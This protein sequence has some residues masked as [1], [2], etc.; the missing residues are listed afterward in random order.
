MDTK[1]CS[2]CGWVVAMHDPSNFCPV[3]GTRFDYRVCSICGE[4]FETWAPRSM[5][6]KCYKKY[7]DVGNNEAM[8]ARRKAVYEEWLEK[9]RQVPKSYPKLTDTQWMEAV[10]HFN[11][12][13][14]CENES[15]DTRGY[16]IPFKDGG[17]Y[18]DWNVI[19]MCS[20]C[21]TKAR[22]NFN[23]FM[24]RK[25]PPGLTNIISYLEVK[26]NAAIKKSQDIR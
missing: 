9:V 21:A 19:P 26:L 15:I 14:L 11:G 5:C 24:G 22:K 18:C 6:K 23:W 25:R 1:T 20:D 8:Q 17:R 4:V 2:K 12:C 16:F 7:I 13:A 10:K 3:C